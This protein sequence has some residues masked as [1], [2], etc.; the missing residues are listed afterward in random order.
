ML[1]RLVQFYLWLTES[2][3]CFIRDTKADI[4]PLIPNRTQAKILAA[5][6]IQ[7]AC[8]Q[9][10]RLRILKARKRGVTTLVQAL[11]FYL[12]AHHRNQV[13]ACLAHITESTSEIFEIARLMASHYPVGA[14]PSQSRIVFGD[15]KSRYWCHTA[16]SQSVGA[17]GTPNML[18]L[19][20]VALWQRHKEETHYASTNAVPDT[21]ESVIVEE[22][23]ARGRELFYN[24]WERGF[25]PASGYASLFVPW[26]LDE[27]LTVAIGDSLERDD[28]ERTLVERAHREYDIALTDESL[29]WRR[30]KIADMS[31]AIFRQEYPSTPEE[32]VQGSQDLILPGIRD[33][34]I[35]RLPF[36]VGKL[37]PFDSYV[38]GGDFGWNDPT[39]LITAYLV[40][41]VV[42]VVQVYRATATLA[43]AHVVGLKKSHTYYCDPAALDARKELQ[44]A[45]RDERLVCQLVPAPRKKASNRDVNFVN[46]EWEKVRK[47][48]VGGKLKILDECSDQLI[49]ESDNLTWA[50][51][52]F[53]NMK[54]DP[55]GADGW[56]HF[57]TLDALRYMVLGVMPTVEPQP[58]FERTERRHLSRREA[59]TL[60]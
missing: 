31:I 36:D 1:G 15:K 27:D 55:Q 23:T 20:E 17:G 35:E 2:R 12:C 3:L 58:M 19:S 45:C 24:G 4:V 49:Y 14:T 22:S 60:V 16:G 38:G 59:M 42:Y 13:A 40:D 47:L 46:A 29:E 37:A 56:A 44:A 51:N 30:R 8:R 6:M 53:P 33:C 54:R 21:T 11:F 41:Q 39:V 34:V 18:H 52:G 57:D 32:A 28:D 43:R 26:Y 7:A 25:D 48:I 9:P 5:M 10:I 50:D